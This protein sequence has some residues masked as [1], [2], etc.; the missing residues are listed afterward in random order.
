MIPF[1]HHVDHRLPSDE[2][3]PWENRA[4]S[5]TR[6]EALRLTLPAPGT[7]MVTV[8]TRPPPALPLRKSGGAGWL[9]RL[10]RKRSEGP[11]M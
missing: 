2:T 1:Y 3:L 6:P 8:Q 11:A 4:P 10:F 9:A 5:R 7:P